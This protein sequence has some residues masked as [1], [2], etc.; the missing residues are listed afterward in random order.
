MQLKVAP[1]QD[2]VGRDVMLKIIS[3]DSVEHRICQDLLRC[4]ITSPGNFQGVL[5]PLAI[6]DTP[7]QFSFIVTPR[8]GH[9]GKLRLFETVGNVIHYVRCLLK[10]LAFLHNHRIA[11]RDLDHQNILVN[12]YSLYRSVY[13]IQAEMRE[14]RRSPEIAYCLFDFDR[15]LQFPLDTPL[16]SCRAPASGAMVA[17]SPYHPLDVS[18]GESEYNPFAFDVACLG[19]MFKLHFSHATTEFPM[20]APLFDKMTTHF[21]SERFSAP[22]ALEF[23]EYAVKTSTKATYALPVT[24]AMDWECLRNSGRYWSTLSP[25]FHVSWGAYKTP[26]LSWTYYVLDH[27][28]D[29]RVGWK[30]LTFLQRVVGM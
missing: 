29:Y 1:A 3:K 13:D 6:L 30:L 11:H 19:N 9:A 16:R 21:I 27:I 26:P 25:S 24:L 12:C 7:H 17:L 28:A 22:E 2:A 4:D 23:L 10:G 14:H 8:W 18:F 20:L 15:A 5:P